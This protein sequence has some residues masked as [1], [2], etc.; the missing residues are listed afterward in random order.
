MLHACT[1]LCLCLP[2]VLRCPSFSRLRSDLLQAL[3]AALK[4]KAPATAAGHAA[5]SALAPSA[6]VVQHAQRELKLGKQQLRRVWEVLLYMLAIAKGTEAADSI[7]EQIYG[8][9]QAQ[10]SAAEKQSSGEGGVFPGA[11]PLQGQESSCQLA[12]SVA[13]RISSPFST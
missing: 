1:W 5:V 4:D 6:E 10:V 8:R 3:E 9:I 13:V 7:Q 11:G 2:A 12:S